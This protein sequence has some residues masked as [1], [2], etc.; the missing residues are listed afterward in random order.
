MEDR[1]EFVRSGGFVRDQAELV[2]GTVDGHDPVT[3]LDLQDVAAR[4]GR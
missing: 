3:Q 2:A 4:V 1:G